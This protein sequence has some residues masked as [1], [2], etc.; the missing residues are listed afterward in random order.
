MSY[1]T[2][3]PQI[4]IDGLLKIL[5]SRICMYDTDTQNFIIQYTYFEYEPGNTDIVIDVM[6]D[7]VIDVMPDIVIDVLPDNNNTIDNT[8]DN[9]INN[10]SD[11]TIDNTSDNTIDNTSD[12]TINN[13]SDNTI[14]NTS[15]NTIDN[16]SDNTINNTIDNTS[17]TSINI[18]DWFDTE[19][20]VDIINLAQT[21]TDKHNGR[22]V[23]KTF[24]DIGP[25]T[26]SS[27]YLTVNQHNTR[28]SVYSK[29]PK[30]GI[31]RIANKLDM[32]CKSA[33]NIIYACDLYADFV[34]RHYHGKCYT[35]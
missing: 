29:N 5:E 4:S 35:K 25:E 26:L 23:I 13:T 20:H 9:T 1:A 8:S 2:T 15:D 14:D 12:N 34:P 22:W 6:P 27:V 33:P 21:D 24:L 31:L 17:V 10:T 3:L 11:N 30:Y 28:I 16:T 32:R 18:G 7:I 19:T